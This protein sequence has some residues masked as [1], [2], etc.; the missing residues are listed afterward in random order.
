MW[1]ATGLSGPAGIGRASTG[2]AAGRTRWAGSLENW[3]SSHDAALRTAARAALHTTPAGSTLALHGR[4]RGGWRRRRTSGRRGS[5]INGAWT[6]LRRNH[7]TLRHNGLLR[8]RFGRWWSCRSRRHWSSSHRSCRSDRR[9]W[10]YG[11]L[12]R[13]NRRR[14]MLRRRNNHSGRRSG[15]F[16]RIYR[17]VG[18]GRNNDSSFRLCFFRLYGSFR[19]RG[20]RGYY[21]RFFLHHG[22]SNRGL[23]P[24]RSGHGRRRRC[25]HCRARRNRRMLLLH[26]FFFQQLEHIAGF[27]Y[28]GKIELGLD[29]TG[30]GL[31][32]GND[33][34]RLVRKIP[35]YL[36][37]LVSFD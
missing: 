21:R 36:L 2:T 28:L 4:T 27:G 10:L 29:L 22:R 5:L 16:N 14:R 7:S 15:L 3:L 32:P 33:R 20:F 9:F 35:S 12:H 13:N 31:L 23:R 37:S 17:S 8:Y 24:G 6:R 19:H 34:A 11:R 18:W 1:T 26:F 30:S 25:D